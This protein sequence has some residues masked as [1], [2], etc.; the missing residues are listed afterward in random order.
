[1]IVTS[2]LPIEKWNDMVQDPSTS[3]AIMDRMLSNATNINLKGGSL[4][5]EGGKEE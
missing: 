2:H 1:M 4:R 3:D 5:R